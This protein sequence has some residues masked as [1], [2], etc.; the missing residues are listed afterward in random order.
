MPVLPQIAIEM[1]VEEHLATIEEGYASH[2]NSGNDYAVLAFQDVE[3]HID[4]CGMVAVWM[5]KGQGTF[6]QLEKLIELKAG[7]I[8]VFDDRV[9]HSFGADE[10]CVAVNFTLSGEISQIQV[11]QLIRNFEELQIPK[12]NRSQVNYLSS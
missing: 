9:E 3:D 10:V 6:F 8:L 11:E 7:D 5:I 1:V 2:I 4:G 12:Q